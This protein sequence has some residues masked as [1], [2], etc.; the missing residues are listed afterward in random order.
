VAFEDDDVVANL[1]YLRR[2]GVV[3]GAFPLS[4]FEPGTVIF[5]TGVRKQGPNF[6]PLGNFRMR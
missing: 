6:R 5:R 1:D 4:V 3:P 2:E